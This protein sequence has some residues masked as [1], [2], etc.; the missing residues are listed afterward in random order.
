VSAEVDQSLPRIEDIV[1]EQHMPAANIG[2]Q[3]GMD[4]QLPRSGRRSAVA[5]RLYKI[6]PQRQVQLAYQ[7]CK[8]HE[9]T[10]KYADDG[11]GSALIIGSNL[12]SQFANSL[13]NLIRR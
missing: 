7:V 6:D 3:P 4:Y 2:S 12:P 9:A 5:R 10:G 8:E 1:E 11:D 13:L